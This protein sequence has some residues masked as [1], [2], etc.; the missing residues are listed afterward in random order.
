M[1]TIIDSFTFLGYQ[2][3]PYKYVAK[4]DIFVCS[5]R[6][7]GYS[8]AVSEAL[9]LGVPVVST[10]CSGSYELL[11]N[12]NEYGIVTE[13]NEQSL[14]QGIKQLIDSPSLLIHYK[15]QAQLRKDLFSINSTV[16]SV[17]ATLQEL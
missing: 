9:I 10:N 2:D 7:E 14:Y 6:S 12:N 5:S 3:N 8:T 4:A 13:N 1:S 11:G 15:K 16:A 17:E